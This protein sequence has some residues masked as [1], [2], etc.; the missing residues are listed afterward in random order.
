MKKKRRV[1]AVRAQPGSADHAVG[2]SQ[3]KFAQARSRD[4]P[5]LPGSRPGATLGSQSSDTHLPLNP[6]QTE[7][8]G[9]ATLKSAPRVC[10][11]GC[12]AGTY[13]GRGHQPPAKSPSGA[14]FLLPSPT[15]T[16]PRE[17]IHL[18]S[19]EWKG[20]DWERARRPHWLHATR[21]V[22]SETGSERE[23]TPL[24]VRDQGVKPNP[25][26]PSP[27]NEDPKPTQ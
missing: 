9:C 25:E 15:L 10:P 13:T 20:T 26:H 21:G 17:P 19:G 22:G 2:L 16:D 24:L 23:L 5:T 6:G 4:A 18:Q 8:E 11:E 1:P 14:S 3:A 12:T 7:G 27:G